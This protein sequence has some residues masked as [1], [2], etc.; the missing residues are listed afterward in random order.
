[1]ESLFSR[2]DILKLAMAAAVTGPVANPYLDRLL[3]VESSDPLHPLRPWW[4]K[5]VN[6]PTTEINWDQLQRFDE[7]RTTR[8]SFA[9]YVGK[10]RNDQLT[11]LQT[12]T[13]KK[14]I[15][16]NKPG[17][18]LRDYALNDC[19]NNG[20]IAKSFLGP[21]KSATPEQ[22][23][24]PKWTGTPE[25]AAEMIRAMLVHAGAAQVGFVHLDDKTRKLVYGHDPAPDKKEL[26]FADVDQPSENDTTRIIPNK[27]EW[28]IVY[29]IQMSGETLRSA[30][31]ETACQ[32]TSL[33][34]SRSNNIQAQLQEFLRGLGYY[35]LGEATTNALGIA[36]AFG[37]L[38][39]LGELGRTNRLISPEHG[40]MV[41]VF[42]L[43]TNLPLPSS[44]P[45]DA[46]I[47]QFCKVC[48]KCAEACPSGALSME[49]EPTWQVKGPWNNPGHKAWFEDSTKCM[50]YWRQITNNCTTCFS[51]CPFAKK[52][53]ALV[54]ALVKAAIAGTPAFDAAFRNMDD[55]LGYGKPTDPESWWKQDLA[56]Y[57]IDSTRAHDIV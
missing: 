18:K 3:T 49:M 17:F 56:E 48:K 10:D 39:G 8:G 37:V 11:A 40:T 51:V 54:H 14:N 13:I 43:I 53:K 30:P 28:V 5:E 36:P 27:A 47:L 42:K 32:T 12:E 6:N 22:R 55:M 52:D 9:D 46:G 31:S 50:T 20:A 41:R 34:Y 33:T 16:A 44:K 1:M 35:G 19:W 24:V 57:G 29:T 26:R 45:I 7:W 2:R 15:I 4:V 38:A 23:G 25:E 21:G